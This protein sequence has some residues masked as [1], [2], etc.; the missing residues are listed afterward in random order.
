MKIIPSPRFLKQMTKHDKKFREKV[1]KKLDL[2]VTNKSHPSLRY[3][4]VE[5]LKNEY[6]PVKCH[7]ILDDSTA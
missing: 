1:Y 5:A 3:K 2:F 4:S 6:P 7:K